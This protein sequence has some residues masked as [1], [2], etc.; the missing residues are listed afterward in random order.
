MRTIGKIAPVHRA[1]TLLEL[2]IVVGILSAVAS[3]AIML[4]G[5]VE[6]Q[7]RTQMSLAEMGQLR[8]AI[9][10]FYT[11]T[12]YL[13]NQGPFALTTDDGAVPVPV[14]GSTWF[15]H[16]ANLEQLLTNP[17]AGTGHSLEVW[18]PDTKRGWRGPYISSFGEGYVDIGADLLPDGTGSP[19]TG[20]LLT[21]VRAVADPFVAKS[22]GNYFVWRFQPSDSPLS[23]WGRPYL[24]ID[25]DDT[26]NAR[27]IGMGPNRAYDAG[28]GDDYVFYLFQ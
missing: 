7:A 26:S 18:D 28:S 17:L 8:E 14:E 15:Y 27:I 9:L 12:G 5:P 22:S 16:P 19:V 6:D 11:D 23:Q 25:A 3:G 2:M 20:T 1:F 13:P 4:L 24:L 10:N 21:Q